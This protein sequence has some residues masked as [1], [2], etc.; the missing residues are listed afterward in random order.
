MYNW[1]SC[2]CKKKRSFISDKVQGKSSGLFKMAP[3][4]GPRS[5][6]ITEG[7]KL[8]FPPR[9][10]CT[11]SL[12]PSRITSYLGYG[13]GCVL[14][15]MAGQYL[16]GRVNKA[17][18]D[19]FINE[20]HKTRPKLFLSADLISLADLTLTLHRYKLFPNCVPTFGFR[21]ILSL[22]DE[23]DHFNE[24]VEKQMVSRNRDAPEGGFDAI[25]QA[26]VCKVTNASRLF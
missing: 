5:W 11:D 19:V 13:P 17:V 23:V 22:T 16:K 14:P 1:I 26:A 2:S 7:T 12:P 4:I 8:T 10:D 18:H 6:L 9:S 3:V 15:E 21:H 25:L 24:E 20:W